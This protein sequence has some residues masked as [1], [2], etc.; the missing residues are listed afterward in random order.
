VLTK[1]VTNSLLRELFTLNISEN[2]HLILLF[3]SKGGGKR[4]HFVYHLWEEEI[5]HHFFLDKIRTSSM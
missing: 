1:L 4:N 5:L 3:L 2:L